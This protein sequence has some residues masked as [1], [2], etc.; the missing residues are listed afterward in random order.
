MVPAIT[1]VLIMAQSIPQPKTHTFPEVKN[2]IEQKDQTIGSELKNQTREGGQNQGLTH[3]LE[4][5]GKCSK[6]D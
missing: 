6:L 2:G 4:V 1:S 5:A 3:S